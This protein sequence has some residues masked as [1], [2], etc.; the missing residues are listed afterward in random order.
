MRR[1]PCRPEA[2]LVFLLTKV[3][4]VWLRLFYIC[5][6]IAIL[7]SHIL[8]GLD[9]RHMIQKEFRI[10]LFTRLMSFHNARRILLSPRGAVALLRSHEHHADRTDIPRQCRVCVGRKRTRTLCRECGVHLCQGHCF[11]TWHSSEESA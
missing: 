9:H 2:T 3:H 8:Y 7:N 5:L 10:S 4:A 1:G 6:D 11:A